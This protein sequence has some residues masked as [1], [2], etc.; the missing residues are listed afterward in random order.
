MKI[1]TDYGY[2]KIGHSHF[3]IVAPHA[4]GDDLKTELISK[5][6]AEKLEA[7]LVVNKIYKKPSNSQTDK[8]S[9]I[10]EDFNN[11]TWSEKKNKYLWQNKKPA[12]K[13]F[14]EDI[15]NFSAEA[16]KHNSPLNKAIIIYIHGFTSEYVAVDIGAGAK[17]HNF[18]NKIFG[19]L[20]HPQKG[21]NQG[22]I[23]LPISIIKK[24]RKELEK[25]IKIKYNLA[26]TIGYQYSGWSRQS[27]IQFH[28]HVDQDDYALQFEISQHL[29]KDDFSLNFI[30]ETLIE[31]IKKYL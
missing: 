25:K 26:T 20:Y 2:K 22:K 16:K 8:N 5:K 9:D 17:H 21:D 30:V 31:V 6:I 13:N 3:V 11:L 19:S 15:K 10:I 28:C 14:F 29:R 12:M 7:F 4:A 27:A 23:T 18:S 24:I 1:A